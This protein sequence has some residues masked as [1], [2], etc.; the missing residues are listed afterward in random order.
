MDGKG[1]IECGEAP[2][3]NK[4]VSV[5]NEFL[6]FYHTGDTLDFVQANMEPRA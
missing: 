1:F 4:S 2:K 3:T 5:K 6:Y